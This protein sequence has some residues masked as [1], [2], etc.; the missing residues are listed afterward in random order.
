MVSNAELL[1]TRDKNKVW[2]KYCGFFDLSLKEFQE[3]QEHLLLEQLRAISDSP[4]SKIIMK[5]ARPKNLPEFRQQ[6]PLTRYDDYSPYI[7]NRQEEYLPQKPAC[8]A[9]TSGKGGLA[10]WVPYTQEALD[11]V[12]S[13]GITSLILSCASYRGEVRIGSGVKV[14]QNL[15]PP[16]YFSGIVGEALVKEGCTRMIPPLDK[17]KDQPFEKRMR[18]GYKM[19]LQTPIDVLGSLTAVLIKMG[20]SFTENHSQMKISGDMLHP[21]ILLR[22]LTAYLKSKKEKRPLLPKDLW[23]LK[24]LICYG[25][26]TSIYRQQLKHYWGKEPLELYS[27]TECAILALQAWNKKGLTFVPFSGFLEFI[28]EAEWLKNRQNPN[29]QPRTILLNEVRSG[30]QYEVV[31]TNFHGMPF[32]RY[33]LGDLIKVVSMQDEESGIQL[34]QI[35]FQSRGDDI[36]DINGFARLDEKTIWQALTGTG[37]KFAGWSA[38][39][40]FIGSKPVVHIYLEPKNGAD[41]TDLGKRIHE[42]ILTISKDY[43]DLHDMLGVLP[44]K[45]TRLSPGSFQRYYESRS[46]AGADLAHLKPPQMNALDRDIEEFLVVSDQPETVN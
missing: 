16:P 43:R 19:A 42:Q 32:L 13:A 29:Y 11:W 12:T 6:V 40:E 9:R 31:F 38:R 37:V 2:N 17:Y 5:G 4:L 1:R 8:W 18:D 23:P 30:N 25:M 14:M 39:K 41:L 20:E 46:K 27:S 28:P 45:V 33:R 22:F 44:V 36:L 7:G 34:P 15:A 26:D 21:R 35:V 3:I 24:G 10:K